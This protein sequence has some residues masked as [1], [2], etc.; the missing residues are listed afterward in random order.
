M[1]TFVLHPYLPQV[2]HGNRSAEVLVLCRRFG[3]LI[4]VQLFLTLSLFHQLNN[5]WNSLRYKSLWRKV[6]RTFYFSIF[7][8]LFNVCSIRSFVQAIAA[9]SAFAKK[10]TWYAYINICIHMLKCIHEGAKKFTSLQWKG[11]HLTWHGEVVI[12]DH[13]LSLFDSSLLCAPSLLEVLFEQLKNK[14]NKWIQLINA[15]SD[16]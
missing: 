9:S 12:C 4:V 14:K 13:E 7:S 3:T 15:S 11:T 1:F 5:P 10:H 8:N 6:L 2:L 16:W